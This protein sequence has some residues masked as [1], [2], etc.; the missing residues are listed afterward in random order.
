[1][2]AMGAVGEGSRNLIISSEQV[3]AI[4]NESKECEGHEQESLP[5]NWIL[6]SVKDS[7]PGLDPKSLDRLFEAFYTTKEH[8]LGM[9]LAISHSI[10]E[11]HSGRLWATANAP[12][13]AVFQFALPIESAPA[14]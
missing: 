11:A 6:V 5:V 1:I 10:I 7:G 13:G 4:P 2:D 14:G 9:G 3:A 12:Q 8:G